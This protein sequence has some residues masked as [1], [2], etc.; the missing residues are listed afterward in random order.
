M[1][2]SSTISHFMSL[3]FEVRIHKEWGV[4]MTSI[5]PADVNKVV[6]IKDTNPAKV[7]IIGDSK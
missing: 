7:T 1:N 3:G 4:V 2:F 5:K 6:I